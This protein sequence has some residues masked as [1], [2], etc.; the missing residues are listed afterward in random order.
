M[1]ARCVSNAHIHFIVPPAGRVVDDKQTK[2]VRRR[3][4]RYLVTI[5][6]TQ[7]NMRRVRGGGFRNYIIISPIRG[8]RIQLAYNRITI[9]AEKCNNITLIRFDVQYS[10]RIL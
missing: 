6:N 4:R 9:Y 10:I 8:A 5:E 3:R 7:R 1:S 2:N